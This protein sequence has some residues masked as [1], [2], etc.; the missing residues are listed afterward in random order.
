M[1][2][3]F[4]WFVVDGAA[5]QALTNAVDIYSLGVIILQVLTGDPQLEIKPAPLRARPA[6]PY[7]AD[8]SALR[9]LSLPLYV[10]VEATA[11]LSACLSQK[12]DARPSA[13][14]VVEHPLFWNAD[15]AAVQTKRLYELDMLGPRVDA[16]EKERKLQTWLE[17]AGLEDAYADLY[18][19]Q[20]STDS[21]LLDWYTE[22]RGSF[23]GGAYGRGLE[24][25]LRFARNALE[26]PPDAAA[27]PKAYRPA[28]GGKAECRAAMAL[29]LRACWPQLCVAVHACLRAAERKRTAR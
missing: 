28:S 27:L 16:R 5:L 1:S 29:Y 9:W 10:Q 4:S 2:I 14:A 23:K 7:V 19:W 11:L 20:G 15:T 8:L 26:H 18:N 22:A 12:P 3:C 24:Q 21:S 13:A 25:L 17:S 6:E